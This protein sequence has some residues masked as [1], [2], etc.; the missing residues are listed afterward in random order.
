[1]LHLERPLW[2]SQKT[3]GFFLFETLVWASQKTSG[4]VH[5]Q[6]PPRIR[7]RARGMRDEAASWRVT[8]CSKAA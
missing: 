2:A 7:P 6:D 1:M 5:A 4:F 3:S 8:L